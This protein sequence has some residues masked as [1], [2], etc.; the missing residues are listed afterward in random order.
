MTEE[1][2]ISKIAELE[3]ENSKLKNEINKKKGYLRPTCPDS[4]AEKYGGKKLRHGNQ[5]TSLIFLY[6]TELNAISN[7]IRKTC[8]IGSEQRRKTRAGANPYCHVT[9]RLADLTDEEYELYTEILDKTL[10]VISQ[11]AIPTYER[12]EAEAAGRQ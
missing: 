9:K 3:A 7:F 1:E 6:N 12:K 8:F 2:M 11:Y 10:E 4:I 5:T